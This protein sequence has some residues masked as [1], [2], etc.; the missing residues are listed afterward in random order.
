MIRRFELLAHFVGD[1]G[2]WDE[3]RREVGEALHGGRHGGQ[4]R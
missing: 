2:G 3:V 4:R 1:G